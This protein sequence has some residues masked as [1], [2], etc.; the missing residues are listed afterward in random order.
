VTGVTLYKFCHRVP[1]EISVE[2]RVAPTLRLGVGA[3]GTTRESENIQR[4]GG[5]PMKLRGLST[6]A[7]ITGVLTTATAHAQQPPAAPIRLAIFEFELEDTSAGAESGETASDT[8]GLADVTDAVRQLL[9]QSGRYDVINVS[10][11]SAD[12]VGKHTLHDCNGCDARIA[13]GLGADQSLVGVVRRISR[14]E[15]TVRFQIREARTGSVV[16][17]GDSGLRM[18][19][20]YSWSRGAISLVRDRLL[21]ESRP[22]Q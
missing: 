19:A 8:R 17:E 9:A 22:Q 3:T 18:G 14:V 12:T 5:S 7:L 6:I 2:F 10:A 1:V 21:P 11:A 16:S 15:Y 4:E 13:L 20:N